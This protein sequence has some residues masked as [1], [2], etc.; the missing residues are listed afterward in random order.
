MNESEERWSSETVDEQRRLLEDL[1]GEPPARFAICADTEAGEDSED[2]GVL[3]WGLAFDDEAVVVPTNGGLPNPF[4]GIK[5]ALRLYGMVHP[6]Q[7]VWVDPPDGRQL[8]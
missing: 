6:V 4:S 5:A 7:L 2:G 1:H 8:T 3:G